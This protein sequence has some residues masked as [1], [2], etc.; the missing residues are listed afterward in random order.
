MVAVPE[1]MNYIG[2]RVP[3]KEDRRLLTGKGHFVD[4]MEFPGALHAAFLRSPYPHAHIKSVDVTE[5]LNRPD[6]ACVMT[7]PEVAELCDPITGGREQKE[8]PHKDYPLALQKVRY[9]GE[10][11]VLVAA[12]DRYVAEDAVASIRVEYEP[13]PA[14]VDAQKAMEPGAPLLFEEMGT[15]RIWQRT[16]R[17]GDVDGAF[18]QA[19]R[20]VEGQ[21]Y[22]HRYHSTPLETVGI[23]AS[24]EAGDDV[25]TFWLNAQAPHMVLSIISRSLRRPYR[26]LRLIVPPDMGGGFG[27]KQAIHPEVIVL[28]LMA[29]KTGKTVKWLEDRIEHLSASRHGS[30]KNYSFRCAVKN[31]GTILGFKCKSV[32]NEG[33]FIRR[34]EPNGVIL[35][36]HIVQGCYQ[37]R[38]IE[39]DCSAVVTNKSPVG[40]NRGYGRMQHGFFLE[41]MMDKVARELGLDPVA[42][43]MKNFLQPDQFPYKATNGCLYDSGDY[44][45]CVQQALD[46]LEYPRW[47]EEQKK[48]RAEGRYMGIGLVSVMETGSSNWA[49]RG[50][51]HEGAQVTTQGEAA[52]ITVDRSGDLLVRV[53]SQGQSSETVVSQMVATEFGVVPDRVH[54]IWPLDTWV[55]PCSLSS[56]IY[57][58]RFAA[59]ASGAVHGAATAIKKKISGIAAHIWGVPLKDVSFQ[60]GGV[61]LKGQPEKSLSLGDVARICL[62]H[63]TKLPEGVDSSLEVSFVYNYP[64][65]TEISDRFEGNFGATY[66]N[67]VH[68][69][70]VEVDPKTGIYSI[71]KYVVVSD[72][73]VMINPTVVEGQIHGTVA[74]TLGAATLEEFAYDEEGNFLAPTF[75]QYKCP[76]ATE[77]P[78]LQVE[79]RISPSPFTTYG[80][81]GVGEGSG[82]APALLASALEDA[83]QQDFPVQITDSRVTPERVLRQIQAASRR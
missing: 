69:A 19:D 80:V 5:A 29:I 4:D 71:L 59:M 46:T 13:I 38:N 52:T 64:K 10:P 47:R 77:M 48:A 40:P 82:P 74:H 44:P 37:M 41:R 55:H 65:T 78:P 8:F 60:Q 33:A 76:K 79:H 35:W 20:V 17:Y 18:E 11:V 58:S 7:G 36:C 67:A 25:L 61:S 32:D 56:G 53:G 81:K 3:R 72:I 24:H 50:L 6:V 1:E 14:V 15:N 34:P 45:K 51:I 83:L 22:F 63:P 21:L 27:I 23:V 39:M 2:Q 73:G 30:E 31:D 62:Y 43:R 66:G 16:F 54:V 12:T 9:V 75:E 26:K 70:V 57:V 68:A 28:G 42:L 49:L